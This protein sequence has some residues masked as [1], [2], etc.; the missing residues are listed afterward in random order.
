MDI[1]PI[2]TARNVRVRSLR[3]VLASMVIHP[4][5][6]GLMKTVARDLDEPWYAWTSPCARVIGL[7]SRNGL[8]YVRRDKEVPSANPEARED[9]ATP[10]I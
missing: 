4:S 8:G 5:H 9:K 6:D 2:S 3:R 10:V 7:K 1:G